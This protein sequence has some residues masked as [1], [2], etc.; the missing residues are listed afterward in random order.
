MLNSNARVVFAAC[1]FAAT[2]AAQAPVSYESPRTL[3]AVSAP[4]WLTASG[5]GLHTAF[6]Q[7]PTGQGAPQVHVPQGDGYSLP[8]MF[9]SAHGD[10]LMRRERYDPQIELSASYLYDA[11]IQGEPG[12]FDLGRYNFDVDLAVPI[13]PDVFLKVGG[14][15]GGRDYMTSDAF[16][17][18]NETLYQGGVRFGFGAFLDDYT[19]LEVVT[20]P[21]LWSDLD[22][23]LHHKDYDFPSSMVLTMRPMDELFWKIGVRYNQVFEEAPWLPVLGINW[24][25]VE[26]LRL[27]ITL[28]EHLELSYWASPSTGFMVGVNVTGGQYHVRSS[29]ATGEQRA[30]CQVQEIIAYVGL[31]HRMNDNLSIFGNLG[32]SLAGDYDLTDGT[33]TFDRVDGDLSNAVWLELGLGFDF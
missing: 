15:F 5:S 33:S 22:G 8:D 32:M 13:Y 10:F 28:P 18:R 31:M 29:L 12:S 20:E 2:V 7:D 6:L 4:D 23:G 27:D 21:G 1:L 26:G 24:E 14:Y 25:I 11:D 3:G 19:L 17:M 9:Q 30:D 16:P